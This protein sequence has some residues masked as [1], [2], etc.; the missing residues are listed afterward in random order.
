MNLQAH[1]SFTLPLLVAV[2]GFTSIGVLGAIGWPGE[3]GTSGM[4]FCEASAPGII[5]QPAN[6]W[7]NLAYTAVGLWIGLR[8]WRRFREGKTAPHGNRMRSRQPYP[9]IYAMV[10]VSIG[11]GSMAMHASTTSWGGTLDI[12]SMFLWAGFVL[13]YGAAQIFRLDDRHFA[14]AYLLIIGVASFF[15]LGQPIDVSGTVIFGVIVALYAATEA[16]ILLRRPEIVVERRYLWTTLALF[17]V[18]LAVWVPS[19]T[20][21][22]L[23]D[24]HSLLQGHALWH[25]LT[26]TAVLS[27]YFYF[28][29]ERTRLHPA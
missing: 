22:P 18:A 6:A 3:V 29:S 17:F 4:I 19:Q 12:M 13:A 11:P 10:A 26:A 9:L 5:K 2:V 20:G 7:S 14:L 28:D 25:V 24:P 21:G 15:Y 8:T 1:H 16:W 23:C 27:L